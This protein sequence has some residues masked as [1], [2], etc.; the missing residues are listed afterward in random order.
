MSDDPAPE[1]AAELESGPDR[2]GV[3]RIAASI[4]GVM[5]IGF[6]IVLFTRETNTGIRVESSLFGQVVPE[7][8][9]EAFDGS[10]FDIDSARGSWV[11]VNFFASWCVPCENEHPELIEWDRRHSDD[12][13]IV[14]IPFGDTEEDARAFFDEIGGDWP[15]ILDPKAAYAVAFGVLQPPES[16]LVAPSGVVVA[17]WL[18]EITADEIDRVIAQLLESTTT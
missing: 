2:P 16:Y 18:G 4:V 8:T 15:V 5:L 7:V 10:T 1:P 6:V 11:L 9:G 14:S 12:A 17:K 3:A 13:L